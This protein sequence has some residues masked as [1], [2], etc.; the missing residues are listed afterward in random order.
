MIFNMGAETGI[1]YDVISWFIKDFSGQSD[2]ELLW[3]I[4][5]FLNAI[6]FIWMKAII[7]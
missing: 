7:V 3:I 4:D 6:R 5:S 2:Q 1:S